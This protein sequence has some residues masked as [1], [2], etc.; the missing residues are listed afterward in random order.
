[1]ID[2]V[3][4][5]YMDMIMR[6]HRLVTSGIMKVDDIWFSR[7][8]KKYFMDRTITR[9][10][11]NLILKPTISPIV[12]FL[13]LAVTSKILDANFIEDGRMKLAN[14][15]DYERQDKRS[16]VILT[17]TTDAR[18]NV[19]ELLALSSEEAIDIVTSHAIELINDYYTVS[20]TGGL[21]DK[22]VPYAVAFDKNDCFYGLEIEERPMGLKVMVK[23]LVSD[24]L[25]EW[26]NVKMVG[27][28][29]TAE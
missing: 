1:M 14:K 18:L 6:A 3:N 20:I 28:S 27:T 19:E 22:V 2:N 17:D 4:G 5:G 8:E 24:A 11:Y 9:M 10:R 16:I 26:D 29:N 12:S 23:I 15:N 13:T 7:G 21:I 25:V